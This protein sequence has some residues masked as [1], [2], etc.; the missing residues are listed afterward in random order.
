VDPNFGVTIVTAAEKVDSYDVGLKYFSD[1]VYA[2]LSVFASNYTVYQQSFTDAVTLQSNTITVGDSKMYG[3]EGTVSYDI[4][5]TLNV[6]VSLG[7]L[8]A[9]FADTADDG[10]AFD[11]AGNN[12]RLAPEVSGAVS[13]N[14]T[15]SLADWIVDVNWLTAYQSEVFFESSNYP[16]LSQPAYWMSDASIKLS[17]ASNHWSVEVFADN[18]FDKEYL[19]DA[20]NTGGGLGIPTFVRGTPMIAG[21]RLYAEM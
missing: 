9:T 20:G 15:V 10:S 8:D 5:E 2:T 14:K 3:V 21:L 4:D 12:F 11:Y 13:V 7:L 19:I 6:N 17:P 1:R 18:V 16:G